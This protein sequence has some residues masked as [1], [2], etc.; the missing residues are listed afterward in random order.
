V[1]SVSRRLRRARQRQ[2][3]GHVLRLHSPAL[4]AQWSPGAVLMMGCPA[5]EPAWQHVRAITNADEARAAGL[6]TTW[7]QL[8]RMPAVTVYPIGGVRG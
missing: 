7:S 6:E 8:S 4:V 5:S 2:V 3:R 1:A